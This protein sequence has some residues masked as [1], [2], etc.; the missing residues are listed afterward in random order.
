MARFDF[1]VFSQNSTLRPGIEVQDLTDRTNGLITTD[2]IIMG[3]VSY[4]LFF[5]FAF[6]SILNINKATKS[7]GTNSSFVL[8]TRGK[9]VI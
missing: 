3:I 6:F 8:C 5:L 4:G 7:T 2:F 1:N 9:V